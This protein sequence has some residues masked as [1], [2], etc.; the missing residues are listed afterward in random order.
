MP[1][2]IK[3]NKPIKFGDG[4]DPW[5]HR[6]KMIE[7][8]DTRRYNLRMKELAAEVEYRRESLLEK[9]FGFFFSR[10]GDMI[11]CAGLV[12]LRIVRLNGYYGFHSA[13]PVACELLTAIS[14]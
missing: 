3:Q 5:H 7:A 10:L 1:R 6:N 11:P 2:K 9:E 14:R 4:P 12:N 8:T 13:L